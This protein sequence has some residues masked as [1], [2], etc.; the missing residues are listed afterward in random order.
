MKSLDKTVKRIIKITLERKS[1][2]VLKWFGLRRSVP[3]RSLQRW[4]LSKRRTL[5]DRLRGVKRRTL[6]ERL[7]GR[8]ARTLLKRLG[9]L[10]IR[11]LLYLSGWLERGP[12][13]ERL[14]IAVGRA[15]TVAVG[16]GLDR[17]LGRK[18]KGGALE[19]A[20]KPL[21]KGRVLSILPMEWRGLRRH[22]GLSLCLRWGARAAANGPGDCR[23]P[24]V[25]SRAPRVWI[26]SRG[27]LVYKK[28]LIKKQNKKKH[29][30][31]T[32]TQN[33]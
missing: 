30:K 2:H 3:L 16:V 10:K 8:K 25:E 6:A 14:R 33:K 18:L 23:V 29:T 31:K 26:V 21:T 17:S 32:T 7:V 20:S 28:K 19:H 1:E 4:V 12:S 22:G 24:A 5:S 27:T 11:T 15:A 13:L 9:G